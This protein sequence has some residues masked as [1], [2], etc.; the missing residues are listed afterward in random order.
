LVL[1]TLKPVQTDQIRD[2]WIQYDLDE[3]LGRRCNHERYVE[4]LSL[5]I[6]SAKQVLVEANFSTQRRQ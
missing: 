1:V 6:E 2:H 3:H 5:T 4:N